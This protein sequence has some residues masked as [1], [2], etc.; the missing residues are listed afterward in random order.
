MLIASP[1]VAR[2][3]HRDTGAAVYRIAATDASGNTSE[4]LEYRFIPDESP[5][6]LLNG[7]FEAGTTEGPLGWQHYAFAPHARFGYI[8]AAAAESSLVVANDLPNDSRWT[9]PI[10]DLVPGARYRV[11]GLVSATHV[12]NTDGGRMGASIAIEGGWEHS[13]EDLLGTFSDRPV[14]LEFTAPPNGEAMLGL[15]LGFYGNLCTGEATF[16]RIRVTRL[17]G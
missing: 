10:T 3:T 9:Q 11:T 1:R 16:K 8:R 17:D 4:P 12:K 15:R 6:L 5:P 13:G 14:T 7:D 2:F